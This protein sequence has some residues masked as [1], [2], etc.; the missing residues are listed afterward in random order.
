[1]SYFSTCY[2]HSKEKKYSCSSSKRYLKEIIM[3]RFNN[4]SA[5]L[6]TDTEGDTV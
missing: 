3:L 1:M 6:H 4:I 2:V 5:V